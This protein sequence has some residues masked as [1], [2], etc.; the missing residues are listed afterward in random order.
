MLLDLMGGLEYM[1]TRWRRRGLGF[2][3]EGHENPPFLLANAIMA[4]GLGIN[5]G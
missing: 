5:M 1:E 2:L 3:D 4:D